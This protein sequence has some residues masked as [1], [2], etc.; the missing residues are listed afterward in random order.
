MGEALAR[1]RRLEDARA[2]LR[3]LEPPDKE[4]AAKPRAS[5]EGRR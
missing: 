5:I 2:V 3:R 1:M 4:E